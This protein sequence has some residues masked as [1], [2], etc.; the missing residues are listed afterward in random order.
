VLPSWPSGRISWFV[1]VWI[2]AGLR[3]GEK[4]E[5]QE[6]MRSEG[7]AITVWGIKEESAQGQKGEVLRTKYSYFLSY[8]REYQL[9]NTEPTA[10]A[11]LVLRTREYVERVESQS[12][13]IPT[14]TPR[15]QGGSAK[16]A[17]KQPRNWVE[18][19]ASYKNTV[20]SFNSVARPPQLLP[21]S[22][23]TSQ[24]IAISIQ[25]A[26]EY[27][28]STRSQPRGSSDGLPQTPHELNCCAA[29][30]A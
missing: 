27:R 15:P 18:T 13:R 16:C 6:R 24:H 12:W 3:H 7:F 1:G 9:F 17:K 23:T 2:Y 21:L 19:A 28:I 10:Q 11:L 26:R 25:A 14:G 4:R 29:P 8:C 5:K 22:T 30:P 20:P